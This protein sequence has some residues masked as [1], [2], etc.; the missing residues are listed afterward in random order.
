[1]L[2]PPQPRQS[3]LVRTNP[4]CRGTPPCEPRVEKY[5]YLRSKP[6][7]PYDSEQQKDK[8]GGKEGIDLRIRRNPNNIKLIAALA[9]PG[10]CT[11]HGYR[12]WV[13]VWRTE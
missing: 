13:L 12:Q 4:N 7:H 10:A 8:L 9:V 2:I 11:P 5:F 3:P 1:M 6:I